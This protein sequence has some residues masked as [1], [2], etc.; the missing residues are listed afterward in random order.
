MFGRALNAVLR[1]GHLVSKIDCAEHRRHYENVRL[2]SCNNNRSDTSKPECSFQPPR[3]PGRIGA[4]VENASGRNQDLQVGAHIKSLQSFSRIIG[5]AKS[6]K[7]TSNKSSSIYD[8]KLYAPAKSRP[9]LNWNGIGKRVAQK[10]RALRSEPPPHVGSPRDPNT[11]ASADI[12]FALPNSEIKRGRKER[13]SVKMAGHSESLAKASRPRAQDGFPGCPAPDPHRSKARLRLDRSE[14]YRACVLADEVEAPMQTVRPV[15]VSGAGGAEHRV[16]PGSFSNVTMRGGILPPVSFRFHDLAADPIYFQ[17]D[18]NQSLR[19]GN[20]IAPKKC[21]SDPFQLVGVVS[22]VY[23]L[24]FWTASRR[25]IVEGGV[26]LVPEP[27]RY[28]NT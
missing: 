9:V 6:G 26:R 15:D 19:D 5:M 7:E 21:W 18:A 12:R 3:D 11:R 27:S 13:S 22:H 10:G 1:D 25:G 17:N 14:Q 20:G 24:I 28:S 2:A 16:V 4:L 23:S 8:E